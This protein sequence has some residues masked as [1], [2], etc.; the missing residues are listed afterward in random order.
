[1]Y[2]DSVCLIKLLVLTILSSQT[3]SIGNPPEIITIGGVL[4]SREAQNVF[5]MSVNKLNF[6]NGP[7]NLHFNSTSIIMDPNPIQSALKLCDNVVSQGVQVMIVSH[8]PGGGSQPPI[9]VSYTCGFYLIPVVG[10]SARDSAFSD[11][12]K[13]IQ[14]LQ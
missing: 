14:K 7:L 13:T 3:R 4:S 10:L 12:V 6:L 9:S 8:P 1:M 11:K 2:P 5:D